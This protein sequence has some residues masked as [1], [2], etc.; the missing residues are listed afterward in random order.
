VAFEELSIRCRYGTTP[1]AD[2]DNIE[3]HQISRGAAATP[4]LRRVEQIHEAS[5]PTS[6]RS[7]C[8]QINR[9]DDTIVD[10]NGR[11]IALRHMKTP[12]V[13]FV[14]KLLYWYVSSHLLYIPFITQ[15]S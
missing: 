2:F 4:I 3:G 12:T 7:R 10:G 11:G 13:K 6:F 9:D 15:L 14:S 5:M 8:K 1:S